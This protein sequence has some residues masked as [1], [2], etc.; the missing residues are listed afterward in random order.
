V[1]L[2]LSL[3]LRCEICGRHEVAGLLS[4]AAWARLEEDGPIACPDCAQ[5]H[6]DWR[7]RL[8]AAAEAR[9]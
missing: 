9:D 2:A 5:Q 8:T 6:A 1:G 3:N 7:E 4:A